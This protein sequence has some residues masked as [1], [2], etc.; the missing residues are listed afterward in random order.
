MIDR[1]NKAFRLS[2]AQQA[3]LAR[4]KFEESQSGTLMPGYAMQN[5]AVVCLNLPVKEEVRKEPSPPPTEEKRTAFGVKQDAIPGFVRDLWFRAEKE[6]MEESHGFK[7]GDMVQTSS[8]KVGRIVRFHAARGLGRAARAAEIDVERDVIKK[9][10]Y[11]KD[12]RYFWT[13][14][15]D[16]LTLIKE[17]S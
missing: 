3:R 16:K 11:S 14:F 6:V 13:A 7:I 10:D 2:D 15:I 1:N 9:E 8:G 5:G 17:Q 12:T 4:T